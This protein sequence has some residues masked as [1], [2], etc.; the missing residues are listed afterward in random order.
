MSQGQRD[1]T[2]DRERILKKTVQRR[3]KGE[4]KE[5]GETEQVEARNVVM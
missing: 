5:L 1:F 4:R 2:V 3:L